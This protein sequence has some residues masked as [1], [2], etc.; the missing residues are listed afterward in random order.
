MKNLVTDIILIISMVI[1]YVVACLFV[2]LWRKKHFVDYAHRSGIALVVFLMGLFLSTFAI[3]AGMTF[4]NHPNGEETLIIV[5]SFV[6]S[7]VLSLFWIYSFCFCI[8]IKETVLIKRTLFR[9]VSIDLKDKET[10]VESGLVAVITSK[11]KTIE[12]STRHLEG[13]VDQLLRDCV[14]LNMAS[15]KSFEI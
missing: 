9:C 13:N 10:I 11:D 14:Y 12:F 6:L 4:I 1:Y 8:Y 7:F 5:S 15:K 3:V 2:V